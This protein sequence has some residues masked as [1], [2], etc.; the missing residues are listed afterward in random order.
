MGKPI[1]LNKTTIAQIQSFEKPEDL[2]NEL[3]RYYDFT[4]GYDS[5]RLWGD[6]ADEFM[7]YLKDGK[8]IN[9]LKALRYKIDCY[10]E[11]KW[12]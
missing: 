10:L 12:D 4:N 7:R 8:S 5:I 9:F 3:S 2:E 11:T 6:S 1:L